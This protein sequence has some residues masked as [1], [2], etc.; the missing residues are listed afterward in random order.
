MYYES[1]TLEFE[2]VKQ[3]IEKIFNVR[4]S[5]ERNKNKIVFRIT[6]ARRYNFINFVSLAELKKNIRISIAFSYSRFGKSD[7]Y[8][9][10]ENEKIINKIH[11]EISKLL[12]VITE[13]PV[14]VQDLRV[15]AIDISNQLEV[16]NVT[17]YYKCN[18]I[19]FKALRQTETNGRLYFDTDDSRRK[20]LDGLD[21]REEGKKRREANTY[22]KIYSKRK[23]EEQTGKDPS[24]HATALRGELTL[25]G[26]FLKNKG[27][28]TVAG[29]NR[30]NLDKI[31]YT[32]LADTLAEGIQQELNYSVRQLTSLLKET[33]TRKIREILTINEHHIFDVKL[34]DIILVPDILN[35]SDRQC[36]TYKKQI[37]EILKEIEVQ[38]EIKKEFSGNFERLSKLLKKIAKMELSFEFTKKGVVVKWQRLEKNKK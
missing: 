3:N 20:T 30:E 1:K 5:T 23:E 6:T 18:D 32:T 36:R 15:T 21:F 31:L 4:G 11:S 27:L 22:F 34:L 24:G 9:L 25:K 16:P 38:G 12:K 17:S 33:N 28:T 35:V 2:R 7:N 10:C 13:K 26:M 37:K 29:I 8:E 19:I 14:R